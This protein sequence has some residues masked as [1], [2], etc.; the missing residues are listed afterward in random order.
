MMRPVFC[1]ASLGII[2]GF[3]AALAFA[4]QPAPAPET[5]QLAQKLV[6]MAGGNE[7]Q[8]LAAI[9]GP[10]TT[11][12]GQMLSQMGT[13][14]P[15]KAQALVQEAVMPMLKEHYPEL[16]AIVAQSYAQVLS[17]DDLKAAIAFYST[18]A[19]QDMVRL[20]P[21]LAQAKL[22]GMTQ[23]IAAIQPELL[24]KVVAAIKAHGWDKPPAKNAG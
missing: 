24:G 5:L 7:A 6:E 10:L 15:A 13:T 12:M 2:I 8:T 18:A 4:Q 14:D 17:Q 20:Q 23:W 21:Q 9:N 11:M 22:R 19:G 3:S 16:A 1:A